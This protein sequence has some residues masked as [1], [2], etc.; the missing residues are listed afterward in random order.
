MT[1]TVRHAKGLETLAQQSRTP[2]WAR[3]FAE[4]ASGA[5]SE[6]G[7][8]PANWLIAR[9]GKSVGPSANTE[10]VTASVKRRTLERCS[11]AYRPLVDID[12]DRR[13]RMGP[14]DLADRFYRF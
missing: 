13:P 12:A 11:A 10:G 14:A 6:A 4:A 1:A 9:R 2:S 8:A 7:Y 5:K 3:V